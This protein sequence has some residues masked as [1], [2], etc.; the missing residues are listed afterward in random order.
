MI[1]GSNKDVF[2]FEPLHTMHGCD[3]NSIKVSIVRLIP[4][5]CVRTDAGLC[6]QGQIIV[7]KVLCTRNDANLL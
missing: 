6:Q 4:F 2:E 3:T 5:D 7:C 1:E